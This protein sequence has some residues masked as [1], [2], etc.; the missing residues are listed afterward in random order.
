MQA[1]YAENS[2]IVLPSR[3]LKKAFIFNL[4]VGLICFLE[5][6]QSSLYIFDHVYSSGRNIDSRGIQVN[7]STL[8]S[9]FLHE[10]LTYMSSVQFKMASIRSASLRSFP[11]VAFETVPMLV[12][13]TM[14]LSRPLK[15]DRW[16]D[17]L[18][19][20]PVG[21]VSS[22]ST[23]TSSETQ[24]T[25]DGCF[26]RQSVWSLISFDSGMSRTVHPQDSSK[27]DVE[28]TLTHAS[29][30]SPFHF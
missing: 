22:S 30:G 27:V 20:V 12:W 6:Y 25:C 8:T 28:L 4:C 1:T 29:L 3:Y 18:G 21:S 9:F 10:E 11:N 19:F 23:L 13:L 7:C 14:A 16:Y 24:A 5:R 2:R 17:V 26:A 15:G